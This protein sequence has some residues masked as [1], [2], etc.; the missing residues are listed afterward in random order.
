M[1]WA[2][3]TSSRLVLRRIVSRILQDS[4]KV[5]HPWARRWAQIPASDL[6]LLVTWSLFFILAEKNES[7]LNLIRLCPF[8]AHIYL[9][10]R[11]GGNSHF[12]SGTYV[13]FIRGA[14]FDLPKLS[15]DNSHHRLLSV[16]TVYDSHDSSLWPDLFVKTSTL[17][18]SILF[19]IQMGNQINWGLYMSSRHFTLE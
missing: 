5:I 6:M 9:L 2:F 15:L 3:S 18:R 11:G 4:C 16:S 1:K 19:Q 7:G 8:W 10:P 13:R 17:G 14:F 12:G